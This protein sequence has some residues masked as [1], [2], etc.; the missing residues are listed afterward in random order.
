VSDSFEAY[1]NP[2]DLQEFYICMDDLHPDKVLEGEWRQF[3]TPLQRELRTYPP[4]PVGSKYVRTFN[5]KR[6]WQYAVLSPTEAEI[7]NCAV[8]AGWVQGVE[9]AAVHV[10]RWKQ[11]TLIAQEHLDQFIERLSKKVERVW[12]R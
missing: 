3:L 12:V 10:G 8:Y 7:G 1:V 4:P 2:K 9:Q 5:L 11:A 6:N